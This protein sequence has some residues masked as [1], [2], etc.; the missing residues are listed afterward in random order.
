MKDMGNPFQEESRDLLSLDTKDIAHH[1]AAELIGT[2]LEKCKVR[3][4]EFMKGLEGEEESTFYEPIKKNRVDFFRQ[5]APTEFKGVQEYAMLDVLPTIQAYSTKYKRTDIVFDVY[6]PSSLKAE[7]R[8][9]RGRGVRRRVTGKGKIPSNWRNFLRENDNKAELFNFLA[10]K[11]ARVATPNVVIVTKEEDAVSNRTINLAGVA[12]CSHEEADTRIFVHARHATE[13]GS[14]VIMVKASDTDVVVIAVSVLQA[15][16]E[17][18]LQQL[19]VAFGQGQ[20]LRWVP[21][22]DLCCTLA[23]KSKGMLFFHAFTGC[24]VISAFRGKG[25]KSAWQT[26]DVCDEASG[27]FSKLSQYP[28]VVDDED[29]KTLEKFVV[30]MYDRSSTAE[31]V[32][33]ARLDM[34]ARKQRPYEAIPPTRSALKQH[35]KRAA[36]QA[37]CIWSQS[38]VRQPET[39]TPANWG[40]TK[41]GDLWQIVWTELSPIAESCQQLTK[42]GCKSECCSRCKCYC[43]GLTCTALCSCRCEV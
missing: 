42:C 19:W 23:E 32:D 14:K 18:G 20:H 37:G 8:S 16:Q 21:V 38:T 9:K 6:R 41:K 40:W 7:T 24:D 22:H 2:H 43:F 35:V 26:W 17:L 28:P 13:A 29:L 11:I 10:D 34:F 1:T 33:D 30:M 3:F 25:K 31:G 4:Q 12:P 36:Y 15:L 39:Q 27:V 5:S